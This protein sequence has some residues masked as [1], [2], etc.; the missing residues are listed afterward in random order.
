MSAT[1]LLLL[2]LLLSKSRE[3]PLWHRELA[4]VPGHQNP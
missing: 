4:I 1:M 2:L 3:D